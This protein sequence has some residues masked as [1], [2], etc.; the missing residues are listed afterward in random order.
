VGFVEGA[1]GDI[2]EPTAG[3]TLDVRTGEIDAGRGRGGLAVQSPRGRWRIAGDE[4][5]QLIWLISAL[6]AGMD[7]AVA[8]R[9]VKAWATRPPG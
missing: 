3:P 7:V 6:D 8:A 4:I 5:E 9:A 2:D 1:P